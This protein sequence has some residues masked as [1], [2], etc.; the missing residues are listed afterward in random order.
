MRIKAIY[1][2]CKTYK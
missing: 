1:K 2:F